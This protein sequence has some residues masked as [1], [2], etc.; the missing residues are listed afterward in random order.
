MDFEACIFDLDGTLLDIGKKISPRTLAA[1][2]RLREQGS[3]LIFATARP[4]RAVRQL[5]L[6]RW[7][8]V[9]YYNGA[10]YRASPSVPLVRKCVHA[11]VLAA[12]ARFIMESE[13]EAVL[14]IERNDRWLTRGSIDPREIFGVAEGP[15]N[16]GLDELLGSPCEKILINGLRDPE[17]LRHAFG[18][19]CA[20]AVTDG[21]ALVQVADISAT[22]EAAV[23]DICSASGIAM[24][25]V[26]CFG[27]D[28]NDL[29]L[30]RACGHPVAM[31][32]AIAELKA[33]AR[34]IT[35]SNEE[36]GVA[37]VLERMLDGSSR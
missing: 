31:G 19:S 27:D 18:G 13:P 6:E 9:V 4:P 1:L 23:R 8:P 10:L 2:E 12:I 25:D 17:S 7:G 3:L 15:E 28:R 16:V 5:D 11:E 33:I 36:E 30:F 32:N 26:L 22:K 34:E 35:A 24:D 29:G 20:I 21:G 37:L 14:S